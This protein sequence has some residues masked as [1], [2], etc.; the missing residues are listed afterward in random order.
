MTS[1]G[2]N[3]CPTPSTEVIAL[4]MI[5]ISKGDSSGSHSVAGRV[6]EDVSW[7]TTIGLPERAMETSGSVQC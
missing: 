3:K 2:E 1:A 6:T 4:E 7:Y 5:N